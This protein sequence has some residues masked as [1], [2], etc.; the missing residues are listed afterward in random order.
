MAKMPWPRKVPKEEKRN[1]LTAF[2]LATIVFGIGALNGVALFG[3][4]L[5]F[6]YVLIFLKWNGW[7]G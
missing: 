4:I 6:L 3:W 5:V 7:Y 1:L 2:V